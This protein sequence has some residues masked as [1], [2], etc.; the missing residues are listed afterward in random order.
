MRRSTALQRLPFFASIDW[1]ILEN[2]G[3]ILRRGPENTLV[4][5][6]EWRDEYMNI[7]ARDDMRTCVDQAVSMGFEVDDR[8]ETMIRIKG[9]KLD[10]LLQYIPKSL[11]YTYN[12]GHM[13]VV[14]KGVGKLSGIKW[15]MQKLSEGPPA[16]FLYMGD[17]DNDVEA[18]RAARKAFIAKPCSA[19]MQA[20]VDDSAANGGA[21]VEAPYE[22]LRGSDALLELVRLEL[23][24]GERD[25]LR[26]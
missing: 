3:L 5:L 4:E 10:T 23:L 11:D 17:D 26:L 9:Q 14:V 1:W 20:A 16:E 6:M 25:E 7:E 8:Y 21:M 18:A 19:A 22:G 15:L 2:G 24:S 12:L 13:D